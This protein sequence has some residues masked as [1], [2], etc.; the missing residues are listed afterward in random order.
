MATPSIRSTRTYREPSCGTPALSGF[1]T[2]IIYTLVANDQHE[3]RGADDRQSRTIPDALDQA[4][5]NYRDDEA[6]VD[7]MTRLS[8]GQLAERVDQ[9]ALA[10]VES[11][12]E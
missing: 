5:K 7:G 2:R 4:A 3:D 1:T 6:L 11:G 8:F 12:I 9:V 10:L